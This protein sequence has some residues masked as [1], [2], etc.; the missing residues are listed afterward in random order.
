MRSCSSVVLLLSLIPAVSALATPQ[1]PASSRRAVLVSGMA[2]A[3]LGVQHP[4]AARAA[5]DEQA[6]LAEIK[7]RLLLPRQAR[8]PGPPDSLCVALRRRDRDVVR[9]DAPSAIPGGWGTRDRGYARHFSPCPRP[10]EGRSSPLLRLCA[11]PSTHCRR[12]ST[13]R[14]GTR[15]A[16]S[17]RWLLTHPFLIDVFS[18]RFTRNGAASDG[19]HLLACSSLAC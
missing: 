15:S 9:Q 13:K 1:P 16:Q 5:V 19:S 2:T 12:S 3:A 4:L 17:S 7:V 6:L 10:T 11:P 14:S 8:C 18:H